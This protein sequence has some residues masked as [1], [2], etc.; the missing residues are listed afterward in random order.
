MP[1]YTW[2]NQNNTKNARYNQKLQDVV[3]S[4]VVCFVVGL[5]Q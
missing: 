3:Q 1:K 5:P 2:V 4:N